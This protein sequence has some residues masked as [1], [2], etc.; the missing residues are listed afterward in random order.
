[1]ESRDP[2]D[3]TLWDL[4]RYARHMRHP[5][6][7]FPGLTLVSAGAPAQWILD[8]V[9]ERTYTVQMTIPEGF[10]AYA[11]IFYPFESPRMSWS[12]V[13]RRN[14]RRPHAEM[15]LET[16]TQPRSDKAIL[17]PEVL[18]AFVPGVLP[19]DQFK[20]LAT[21]LHVYTKTPENTFFGI[22]E[23]YGDLGIGQPGAPVPPVRRLM[24]N[25]LLYTG[26]LT[27]WHVFSEAGHTPDYWWP[28]DRAW[29]FATDT[30]FLW[31]YV[32]AARSCIDELTRSELLDAIETRPTNRAHYGMDSVNDP[33][34]RITRPPPLPW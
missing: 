34:H 19:E 23:G 18:S 27:A 8:N 26:P 25:Y 3:N 5:P 14:S 21:I 6:W 13:A 20:I 28:E 12:E 33:G 9:T 7:Q 30:D 31:A 2:L 32:G 10:E 15:E 4:A 24:R 16:I 22:W 11:R 17:H 29:C 1:M